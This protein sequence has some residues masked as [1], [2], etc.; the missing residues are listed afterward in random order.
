MGSRPRPQLALDTNVL[1]DLADERDFAVTVLEVLAEKKAAV[2]VCPTVLVEL[3]YEIPTRLPP[4]KLCAREK[5]L[6]SIRTWN[7]TPFV[8]KAV[9]NGIA[10]MFSER[11]QYIGILPHGEFN[12]GCILA[13]SA[14]CQ[15][16]FS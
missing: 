1:F 4:K 2:K 12:D 7:I 6:Q 3:Q 16:N 14:L 10:K 11:L 15:S 9:D 8:L 13:E 5:A